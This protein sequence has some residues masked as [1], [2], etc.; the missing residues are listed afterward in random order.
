VVSR[1]F[2]MRPWRF[3]ALFA[4]L[5]RMHYDVAVEGG[6]GSFS[7]ALYAYLTGARYR[8]GRGA[9]LET[10]LNVRVPP[11][12]VSHAY[13]KRVAFAAQLAVRCPDHPVYEISAAEDGAALASL[14]Q[15][16]LAEGSVVQPFV[17]LFV[18]GHLEKR[19]PAAWWIELARS[20]TRLGAQVV[21]FLGPEELKSEW[22]Y[23]HAL[24]PS[25]R[26]IPP[27]PLRFFAALL[28]A[29]RLIVTPDSG[30]MHLA[31]AV[32]VPVIA[33]LRRSGYSRHAR[34]RGQRTPRNLLS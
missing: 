9:E 23:R 26:V 4:R 14:G 33:L 19:W 29:A 28:H 12:R 25:V 34:T 2:V 17:A 7:G 22:R 15:W 1:S 31:V 13:D 32:G 20:L 11:V 16:G 24:P 6:M 18:G 3:V 5:R 8:I 27:Q 10:F 21:V 30:P